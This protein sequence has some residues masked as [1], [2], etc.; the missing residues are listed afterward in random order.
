MALTTVTTRETLLAAATRRNETRP[1]SKLPYD[2]WETIMAYASQFA[3][4]NMR[5]LALSCSTLL[6]KTH[7]IMQGWVDCQMGCPGVTEWKLSSVWRTHADA[8]VPPANV[9]FLPCGLPLAAQEGDI[10]FFSRL[11][12]ETL[13]RGSSLIITLQTLNNAVK[14]GH[15]ELVRTLIK[16]SQPL[17]PYV[18]Q[19]ALASAASSGHIEI[20]RLILDTMIAHHVPL[21]ERARQKLLKY[22]KQHD[23]Q[24]IVLLIQALINAHPS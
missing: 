1:C 11:F 8:L 20:V 3:A 9:H 4:P 17:T 5:S 15:I 19:E 14:G 23:L 16:H 18:C 21:C 2:V 6:E 12:R 24:D 10:L 7:A 22:A 13:K